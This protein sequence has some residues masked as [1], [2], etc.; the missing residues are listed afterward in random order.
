MRTLMTNLWQALVCA[1][2]YIGLY[3]TDPKYTTIFNNIARHE[4]VK[5][6]RGRSKNRGEVFSLAYAA[7]HNMN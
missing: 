1:R 5:Y 3:G 2:M 7:Y 4:L 6:E